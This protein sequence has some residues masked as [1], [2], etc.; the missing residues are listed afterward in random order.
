MKVQHQLATCKR[1]SWEGASGLSGTGVS[2]TKRAG[3]ITLPWKPINSLGVKD[4][5]LAGA[6]SG[7]VNGSSP[8]QCRLA[9][10]QPVLF[11]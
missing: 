6:R 8:A 3:V 10:S 1:T 5:K 9:P 4:E 11:Y 2:E 7:S